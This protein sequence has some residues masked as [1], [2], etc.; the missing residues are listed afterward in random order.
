MNEPQ[1][2]SLE[3]LGN[4]QKACFFFFEISNFLIFV[5][6]SL[7]ISLM[8]VEKSMGIFVSLIIFLFSCVK[9]VGSQIG[10]MSSLVI[11]LQSQ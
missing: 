9:F 10:S 3:D 6:S 5:I 7:Q 1:N 2:S 4:F 8:R 11:G